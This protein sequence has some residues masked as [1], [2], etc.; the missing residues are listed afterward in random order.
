LKAAPSPAAPGRSLNEES[1]AFFHETGIGGAA[2]IK[3]GH[4]LPERPRRSAHLRG[5][6]AGRLI[7]NPSLMALTSSDDAFEFRPILSFLDSLK[8]FF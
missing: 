3:R 1:A 6:A 7:R 5:T 8:T 2:A 4:P